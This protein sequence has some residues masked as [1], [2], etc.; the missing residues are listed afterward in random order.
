MS[1]LVH[2][3]AKSLSICPTF[4]LLSLS[5]TWFIDN[6]F[7]LPSYHLTTA[8]FDANLHP[9]YRRLVTPRTSNIT[10]LP[11]P[12]TLSSPEHSSSSLLVSLT[13]VYPL[14]PKSLTTLKHET[15]VTQSI[16]DFISSDEEDYLLKKVRLFVS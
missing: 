13:N 5:F 16:P 3:I 4:H 14:G 2:L 6:N 11:R 12:R 7:A 8:R 9:T 15:S 10:R 1:C